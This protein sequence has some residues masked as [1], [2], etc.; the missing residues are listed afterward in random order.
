MNDVAELVYEELKNQYTL[1]RQR[2]E[3]LNSKASALF[4]FSGI[5]DT[6]IFGIFMLIISDRDFRTLIFNSEY[7][8]LIISL[9]VTGLFCYILATVL[10]LWSFRMKKH[11][12]A[13]YIE[14]DSVMDVLLA[15]EEEFLKI[16]EVFSRQYLNG[17]KHNHE[18]VREMYDQIFFGTSFLFL[19]I[20]LSFII[21]V[22][23]LF[24]VIL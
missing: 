3:E 7:H 9:M 14:D 22:I 1:E 16:K 19:A 15:K 24:D 13:P 11:T 12:P 20:M 23:I 21:A 6:L 10:F 8:C 4:G 18:K 5:I 17:Y 2:W